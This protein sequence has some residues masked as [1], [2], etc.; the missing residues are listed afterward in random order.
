MNSMWTYTAYM[1]N[2]Y[3]ERNPKRSGISFDNFS[4]F[5]FDILWKNY[6][7]VFHD[8]K[9]DLLCDLKYLEKLKVL[10]LKEGIGFKNKNKLKQIAEVVENSSLLTG[11]K[12]LDTYRE[13][14]DKAIDFWMKRG[15]YNS[16][17]KLERV[18]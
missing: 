9:G 18:Y 15:K 1:L 7:V 4:N 5:V 3:A 13:R 2:K 6:K 17:S 12:L 8:G 16:K 11:V 14:V 10:D